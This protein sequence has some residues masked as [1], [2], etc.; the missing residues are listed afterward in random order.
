VRGSRLLVIGV[1]YKPNVSDVR[2]SPGVEVI[3]RLLQRGA[4]VRYVDPHVPSI[5][6]QG[7]ETVPRVDLSAAELEASD[8]V[9]ITTHHEGI[10]WELVSERAPL[11]LDTRGVRTGRGRSQWHTL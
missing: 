10:D 3:S 7:G 9:V 11:V 1:A 5:V 4:N 2:E 8:L 6:L